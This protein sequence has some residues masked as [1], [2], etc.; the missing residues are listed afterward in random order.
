MC[1]EHTVNCP[2]VGAFKLLGNVEYRNGGQL[3]TKSQCGEQ[4]LRYLR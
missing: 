2:Q 4:L 1:Q 3:L